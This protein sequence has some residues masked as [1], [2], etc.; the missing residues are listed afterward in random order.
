VDICV[1][2]LHNSVPAK[3]AVHADIGVF[4]RQLIEELSS[5]SWSFRSIDTWWGQL[6]SKSNENKA[7]VMVSCSMV[8]IMA[9]FKL[10]TLCSIEHYVDYEW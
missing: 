6:N 2:E 7:A 8:Y 9:L 4:S 5:Q 3:V 1:E 10:Q